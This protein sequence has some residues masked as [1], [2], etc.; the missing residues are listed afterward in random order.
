M[1]PDFTSLRYQTEM[2]SIVP[3]YLTTGQEL[4]KNPSVLQGER[5]TPTSAKILSYMLPK[6]AYTNGI[7]RALAGYSCSTITV[8]LAELLNRGCIYKRSSR[9]YLTEK[10]IQLYELGN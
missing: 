8:A 5:L 6:E 9:Y 2:V 7:L 10:G 4:W 1:I 3:V